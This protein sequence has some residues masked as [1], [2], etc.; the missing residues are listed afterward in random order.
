MSVS[1][2]DLKYY[3]TTIDA[4][5]TQ[6]DPSQSIGGYLSTTPFAASAIL[7]ADV[8]QNS[9][10][11]SL[12]SSLPGDMLL[13]DD[14]IIVVSG[15]TIVSRGWLS[16]IAKPHATGAIASSL[17]QDYL[18]N[19]SFSPSYTQSRCIGV[20][21]ENPDDSFYNLS[22]YLKSPSVNPEVAISLAVEYEKQ[23]PIEGVA[24]TGGSLSFGDSSLI[25][26]YV[27]NY[28][29]TCALTFTGGSNVNLS[30]IVSS[31]DSATG[32]FVL[33]Q[34]L[35]L[36]VAVGDTYRVSGL[37]AQRLVSGV[38]N[39]V[40][41]T[42]FSGFQEGKISIDIGGHRG[43][44]TLAPFETVYLWLQRQGTANAAQY[45]NN[46]VTFTANYTKS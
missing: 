7:T 8:A 28:F 37:P 31:F 17:I 43:D 11:L 27:D 34:S 30:R 14:E 40:E 46:R 41:A 45:S 10:S 4:G 5:N 36:P 18:F 3:Y 42:N 44:A 16:T 22:F 35:P 29:S 20:R 15:S 2:T 1:K 23:T 6:T 38:D 39:P 26:S 24:T 13:I 32:T 25:S 33:N 21:N 19:D 9:V 12:S